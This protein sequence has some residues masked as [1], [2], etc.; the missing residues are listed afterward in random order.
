MFMLEPRAK[1]RFENQRNTYIEEEK[2]LQEIGAKRAAEKEKE[3]FIS[4]LGI[5]SAKE[6][7]T[8]SKTP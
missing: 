2:K 6:T 4:G 3:D 8:G 1:K 7:V 5:K